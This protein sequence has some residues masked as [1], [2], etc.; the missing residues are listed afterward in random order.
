MFQTKAVQKIKTHI[1]CSTI[2]KRK[3]D[4]MEKNVV[5]I[6]IWRMRIACWI[7]NA[8]DTHSECVT[9]IAFPRREWLC[10]RASVIR[11]T[12]IAYILVRYKTCARCNACLCVVLMC[13]CFV[14]GIGSYRLVQRLRIKTLKSFERPNT[15]QY[16]AHTV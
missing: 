1:L 7:T 9:L 14:R 2:F 4:N 16:T 10:E 5:Q 12:Y 3:I 13:F 15:N 6:T 11:Y 8:T